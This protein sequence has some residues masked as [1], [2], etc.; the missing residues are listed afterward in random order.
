MGRILFPTTSLRVTPTS[1]HL[2]L[3][4]RTVVRDFFPR[5]ISHRLAEKQT[6]RILVVEDE[7]KVASFICK[8]LVQSSY[9]V[10]VTHNGEDA[11]A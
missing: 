11:L 4:S 8:G 7:E 3:Q 2:I 6:M 10:D 5:D 9:T 1:I